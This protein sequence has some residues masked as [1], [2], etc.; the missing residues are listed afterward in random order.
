[1][2]LES[3][4]QGSAEEMSEAKNESANK[5]E[6]M[7]I[8][9]EKLKMAEDIADLLENLSPAERAKLYGLVEFCLAYRNFVVGEIK[10]MPCSGKGKGKGK[11]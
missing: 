10:D 6:K 5:R 3:I 4:P 7:R 2:Y 8:D 1:M 11:K 9:P